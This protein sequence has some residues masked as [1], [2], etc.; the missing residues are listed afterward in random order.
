MRWL[1]TALLAGLL[2]TAYV[3]AVS[4]ATAADGRGACRR[5]D[6]LQ[7]QDLDM[8]PDPMVEGQRIRSWKVRVQFDGNRE[9]VAQ[10]RRVNLR[11]G[12]N[13]IDLRPVENYRFR[14]NEH[15]FNVQVD[16]EGSRK[17]VDA[18]RRFCAHQRPAWSMRERGD[19]PSR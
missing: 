15:C 14:G 19:R 17:E 11:P 10:A 12:V 18:A 5:S 9:I 8:S 6:R 4:E 2:S 3:S 16:L 7:I 13:E 1:K